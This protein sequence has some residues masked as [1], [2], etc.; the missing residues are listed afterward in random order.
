MWTATFDDF[1]FV[2]IAGLVLGAFKYTVD[3]C[4]KSKCIELN[5]CNCIKI[6]R[7]VTTEAHIEEHAMNVNYQAPPP[8]DDTTLALDQYT[9]NRGSRSAS[10]PPS[11]GV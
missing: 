8:V 6:R 2:T 7:D 5:L 11:L 1:F 3:F 9:A 4:L 10:L